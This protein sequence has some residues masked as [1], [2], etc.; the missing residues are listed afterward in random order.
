LRITGNVPVSEQLFKCNDVRD[1]KFPN[2]DGIV[3]PKGLEPRLKLTND[4]GRNE[5]IP[6]IRLLLSSRNESNKFKLLIN[7]GINPVNLFELRNKTFNFGNIIVGILPVNELKDKSR[8]FNIVRE[9]KDVGIVP[10]MLLSEIY[11]SCNLLIKLTC[12]GI[13]PLK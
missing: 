11:N 6:P 12:E 10:I 2:E 9:E 13:D 5:G 1:I 7:V 4:A 3:P 8:Y